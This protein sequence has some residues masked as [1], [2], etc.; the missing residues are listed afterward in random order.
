MPEAKKHDAGV[1]E[2]TGLLLSETYAQ[3][4]LETL[5]SPEQAHEVAAE[6]E[7]LGRL[8]YEIGGAAEM[9]AGPMLRG[10]QRTALVKKI[11]SGRVGEPVE[12]LIMVLDRRRRIE[13]IRMIGRSL[14]RLLNRREDKVE[15]TLTTAVPLDGSQEEA[16]AK[17]LQAMLQAQPLLR[18]QV[19]PGIIGG[20]VLQVGDK[21]MDASLR[22]QLDKLRQQVIARRAQLPSGELLEG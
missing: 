2:P 20:M 10:D 18:T 15:V 13:L 5:S 12:A 19:D 1:L 7:E 9:L 4:L 14:R 8:W 21:V 6:L 11:F 3:A 22:K 17:D 16:I